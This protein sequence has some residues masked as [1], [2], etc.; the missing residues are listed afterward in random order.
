MDLQARS[1]TCE[2]DTKNYLCTLIKGMMKALD[3]SLRLAAA[4]FRPMRSD[5]APAGLRLKDLG[6]GASC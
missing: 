3:S 4:R 5:G 1:R 6:C 2:E